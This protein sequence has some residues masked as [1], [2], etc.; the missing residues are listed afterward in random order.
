MKVLAFWCVPLYAVHA[1]IELT[2]GQ[3]ASASDCILVSFWALMF[4]WRE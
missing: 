3:Y 4:L 2:N 1:L